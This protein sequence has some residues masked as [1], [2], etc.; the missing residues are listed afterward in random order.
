[1][2]AHDRILWLSY[3]REQLE[4]EESNEMDPRRGSRIIQQRAAADF[5]LEPFLVSVV[6][7]AYIDV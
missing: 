7:C 3:S 6:R 1:V 2:S 4:A 5:G